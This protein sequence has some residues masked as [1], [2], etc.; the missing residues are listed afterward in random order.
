[1]TRQVDLVVPDLG[2]FSDVEVIEVLVGPG[3]EVAIEESLITLETDKAS[4]DIPS[5]HA[6]VVSGLKVKVGD[7]VN[8]GDV[9]LTLNATSGVE[10]EATV[11][12]NRDVQEEILSDAIATHEEVTPTRIECHLSC[13]AG[14]HW[15]GARRL[16]GGVSCRRSRLASHPGRA[17]SGHWRRLPECWLHSI[18]SIAAC[19]QGH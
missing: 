11:V 13:T 1:M 17:L 6:G 19:S 16:H 8:A 14:C 5:T 4:M 2:E 15:I 3:D 12:L 7:K 9:I 18:K 10:A